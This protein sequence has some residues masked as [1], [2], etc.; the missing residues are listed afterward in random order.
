MQGG[1]RPDNVEQLEDLN[2][3]G[4]SG[5][6]LPQQLSKMVN[7]LTGEAR[8]PAAPPAATSGAPPRPEPAAPGQAAAEGTGAGGAP[9]S[10]VEVQ[11]AAAQ[12]TGDANATF[13]AP[14]ATEDPRGARH[15]CCDEDERMRAREAMED[16]RAAKKPRTEGAVAARDV[17]G[18][19]PPSTR[20]PTADSKGYFHTLHFGTATW[21]QFRRRASRSSAATR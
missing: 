2:A 6:D 18:R 20:T 14:M 9:A 5:H 19:P 21:A 7:E 10:A 16:L 4:V 15:A 17:G 3:D 8:P 12:P 1:I 13:D 11:P